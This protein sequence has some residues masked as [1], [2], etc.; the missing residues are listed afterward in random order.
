MRTSYPCDYIKACHCLWAVRVAKWTLTQTAIFLELNVGT[1]SYVV[2]GLRFPD[3]RPL[4]PP[5]FE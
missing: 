3:A 1:V 2:R 5:G 4:P